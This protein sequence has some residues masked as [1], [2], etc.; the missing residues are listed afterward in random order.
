MTNKKIFV[1]TNN[2]LKSHK[3]TQLIQLLRCVKQN[4]ITW[5][6]NYTIQYYRKRLQNDKTGT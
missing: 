6:K 4:T 2:H 1:L 3:P 5:R